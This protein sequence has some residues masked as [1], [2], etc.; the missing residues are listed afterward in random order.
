MTGHL[1]FVLF[2]EIQF[3]SVTVYCYWHFGQFFRNQNHKPFYLQKTRGILFGHS[4]SLCRGGGR[5]STFLGQSGRL[6]LFPLLSLLSSHQQSDDFPEPQDD[7]CSYHVASHRMVPR[8]SSLTDRSTERDSS[9]TQ[10]SVSLTRS[11]AFNVVWLLAEHNFTR[12]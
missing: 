5:P 9:L 1:K 7:P 2:T 6:S 12:M 8:S 11:G 3:L 4:R 10:S